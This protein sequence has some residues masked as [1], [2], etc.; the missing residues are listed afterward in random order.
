M[1]H[2]KLLRR[3]NNIGKRNLSALVLLFLLVSAGQVFGAEILLV[4]GTRSCAGDSAIRDNLEGRG[5]SVTVVSD[6]EAQPRDALEK[7]LVVI[8]ESVYSRKLNTTFRNLPVPIIVSEPWLFHDMG[9][10]GSNYG[11]DFGVARH[12]FSMTVASP[13]HQMADGLSGIISTHHRRRP[14]G[15]GLPGPQAIKI[16]TL[17]QDPARYP[18]FAYDTGAQMPGRVAPAKRVG[19]F[20]HRKTAAYLT[21]E[22]WALF[23]AAVDWC[24]APDPPVPVTIKVVSDDSWKTCAG[25]GCEIDGWPGAAV[26]GPHW[27][28]ADTAFTQLK[29]PAEMLPGTGAA[30]MWFCPPGMDPLGPGIPS[31][32]YFHKTFNLAY[33][34]PSIKSAWAYVAN[35]GL[36]SLY[37]NGLPVLEN[38]GTIGEGGKPR[39]IDIRQYL[40]EGENVIAIYA[41]CGES[42]EKYVFLDAAIEAMIQPAGGSPA[43]RALLVVGRSPVR[44]SDR[45]IKMRLEGLGYLVDVIDDDRLEQTVFADMDLIVISETVWSVR[46]GDTLSDIEIPVVCFESYLYDDLNMTGP[47]P[48]KN[49]GNTRRQDRLHIDLPDHQMAAGQAHAVKVTRR[50]QPMGWGVPTAS[51]AIIATLEDDAEKA[52]IFSY[53]AGSLMAAGFAAPARRVGMFPHRHTAR[54]LTDS[55]WALFDA[56]VE[57]ATGE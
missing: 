33:P 3:C 42:S 56:A 54:W 4:T 40:Q 18:V 29:Q 32:A 19:F 30:L 15:W 51:A 10:T 17:N 6:H 38:A 22:G 20:L 24:L 53:D 13:Q 49:Y 35:P 1:S 45:A 48:N 9:M 16:A 43:D 37:I 34:S 52:T 5:F 46:V 23:D 31:M 14:I 41:E 47:Q 55:G 8:S 39:W 25:E 28:T 11:I 21:A 44:F 50:G 36:L 2:S 27:I 12:Q 7:D 57:W 26:V